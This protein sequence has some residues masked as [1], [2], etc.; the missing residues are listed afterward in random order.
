MATRAAKTNS[1]RLHGTSPTGCTVA[2]LRV[3][4]SEQQESGAGLAAQRSA[5]QAYA[6]RHGLQVT[7]G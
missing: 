7:T 5:I 4:T 1:K 2:Y 6:D 3:S